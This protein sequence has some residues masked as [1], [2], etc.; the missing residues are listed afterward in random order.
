MVAFFDVYIGDVYVNFEM[1]IGV[2]VEVVD[3]N[4]IVDVDRS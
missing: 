2:V 3:V 1:D 4:V